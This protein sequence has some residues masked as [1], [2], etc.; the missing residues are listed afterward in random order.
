V[1]ERGGATEFFGRLDEADPSAPIARQA[2]LLGHAQAG[3]RVTFTGL[4][5]ISALTTARDQGHAGA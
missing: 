1:S 2:A 4:V 3:L 5:A